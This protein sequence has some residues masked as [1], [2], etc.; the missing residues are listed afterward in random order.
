MKRSIGAVIAIAMLVA[1]A[2]GVAAHDPIT[3]HGAVVAVANPPTD[4]EAKSIFYALLKERNAAVEGNVYAKIEPLYWHD[5][6]L[7]VLRHEVVMHG[8]KAVE[9]YWKNSLSKPPRKEPFRIHYNDDLMVVV[10]GDQI[11]GGVTWSNQ[12]GNNPPHYGC[13]TLAL[14]RKN[15]KWVIVHEHSSN[16]TKPAT[17][18]R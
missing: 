17:G 16:W 9:A 6:N 15:D 11:V 8:W 13:L 14:Q 5:E 1:T 2:S 4:A 10:Q 12:L 18:T 7:L 3:A